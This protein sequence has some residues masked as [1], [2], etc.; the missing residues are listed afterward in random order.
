[1]FFDPNQADGNGAGNGNAGAENAGQSGSS[2]GQPWYSPENESIGKRFRTADDALRSYG[3]L[4]PRFTQTSQ[5]LA[6]ERKF[7]SEYIQPVF[8]TKENYV[9]WLNAELAKKNKGAEN[10]EGGEETPPD[11]QELVGNASREHRAMLRDQAEDLALDQFLRDNPQAIDI[12]K[13]ISELLPKY[14]IDPKKAHLVS[15]HSAVLQLAFKQVMADKMIKTEAGKRAGS[16]EGTGGIPVIS[17]DD[18]LTMNMDKLREKLT[19]RSGG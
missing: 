5:Q 19:S 1:M 4:E 17:D 7:F 10:G 6:E 13:E 9:N 15:E 16:A 8:G 11:A 3:E 12:A 18:A 2:S 14:A